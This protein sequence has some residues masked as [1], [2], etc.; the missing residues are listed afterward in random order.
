MSFF[1]LTILF[2]HDFRLEHNN[3][4]LSQTLPILHQLVRFLP[5]HLLF[6][7]SSAFISHWPIAE[8]ALTDQV[9][10]S[11]APPHDLAPASP[12]AQ[13]ASLQLRISVLPDHPT[14]PQPAK[15]PS[16]EPEKSPSP[17]R[18]TRNDVSMTIHL[19]I[20]IQ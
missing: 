8:E 2:L 20:F 17:A 9:A 6:I 11:S 18:E 14:S 16:V 7:F 4:W 3:Q 10:G 5:S 15:E 13:P 19:F 12:R 1:S